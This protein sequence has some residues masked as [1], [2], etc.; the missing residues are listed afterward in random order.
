MAALAAA[1]GA[2]AAAAGAAAVA[3]ARIV[4]TAS[5]R[6][7]SPSA[8]ET[9][10]IVGVP[11][12]PETRQQPLTRRTEPPACVTRV[13]TELEIG[14]VIDGE[15]DRLKV[16]F[17]EPPPAPERRRRSGSCQPLPPPPRG[18]ECGAAG[19]EP[20]A[21]DRA[22]VAEVGD[23]E[24]CAAV[25]RRGVSSHRRTARRAPSA[26]PASMVASASA[27]AAASTTARGKLA[28]AGSTS[29]GPTPRPPRPPR[30]PPP[31]RPHPP[32]GPCAPPPLPPPAAA[33]SPPRRRPAPR[34]RTP[35]PS[36]QQRGR[37]RL[38]ARR[39]AAHSSAEVGCSADTDAD[40]DVGANAAGA[41]PPTERSD[42]ARAAGRCSR[43]YSAHRAPPCPSRT[44]EGGDERARRGAAASAGADAAAW[45]WLAP[46]SAVTPARSS[47][48][49][50]AA[51]D[52]RRWQS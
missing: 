38:P 6:S 15:A 13:I 16:A 5:L 27:K 29:G 45:M 30:L 42:R 1:G 19:L 33:A 52:R 51:P 31:H 25:A 21:E 9:A 46:R 12:G 11:G 44:K 35:I 8:R 17:A 22:G 3:C 26:K 48:Y 24:G 36:R 47:M 43:A 28:I 34:P 32:F 18:A 40:V 23:I 2:L 20:A 41:P 10:S 14:L 37:R 39:A 4:S 7:R 49:L 50:A